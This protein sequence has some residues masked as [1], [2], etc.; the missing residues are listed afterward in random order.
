MS[1][2]WAYGKRYTTFLSQALSLLET[3]GLIALRKS[4]VNGVAQAVGK[5]ALN[6]VGMFSALLQANELDL[7]GHGARQGEPQPWRH[8]PTATKAMAGWLKLSCWTVKETRFKRKHRVKRR[9]K[10]K[11]AIG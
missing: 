11:T 2:V 7:R 6:V 5:T 4:F 1:E 8:P 10:Q 9:V 3:F